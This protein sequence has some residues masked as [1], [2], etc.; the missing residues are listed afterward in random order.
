MCVQKNV[1]PSA[2]SKGSKLQVDM[3]TVVGPRGPLFVPRIV[4][5]HREFWERRN[6]VA[7][8]GQ[9]PLR[10]HRALITVPLRGEIGMIIMY[11]R[12]S[13]IFRA[14]L[15]GITILFLLITKVDRSFMSNF[16]SRNV[17]ITVK[18]SYL[19]NMFTV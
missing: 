7:P 8:Q 16:L 9:I 2:Y 19:P 10:L 1:L 5:Q 17:K 6:N 14:N 12:N 11:N 18:Y 13:V 3:G 15:S 4:R